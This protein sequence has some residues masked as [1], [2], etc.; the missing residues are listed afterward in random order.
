VLK[1]SF[2]LSKLAHITAS[3]KRDFDVGA[4]AEPN[5][6]GLMHQITT[7]SLVPAIAQLGRETC[8]NGTKSTCH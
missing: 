1:N 4:Q 6:I 5:F 8:S 2:D 7:N 3:V